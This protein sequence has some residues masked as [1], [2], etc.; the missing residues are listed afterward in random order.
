MAVI[1]D[2]EKKAVII[3]LNSAA[4]QIGVR[5]RDDAKPGFGSVSS[6][7][8]ENTKTLP[9]KNCYKKSCFTLPAPSR[10]MSKPLAPELSTIQFTDNKKSEGRR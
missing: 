7:G 8:R 3:Q 6:A 2:Q 10:P 9:R 5:L 1:D 4:A